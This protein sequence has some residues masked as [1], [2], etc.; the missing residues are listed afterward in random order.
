MTR[1]G[2][3]ESAKDEDAGA[4]AGSSGAGEGSGLDLQFGE[5]G[6]VVVA[7]FG[8]DGAGEAGLEVAFDDAAAGEGELDTATVEGADGGDSD[9]AHG[10]SYAN[11][12]GDLRPRRRGGSG[13]R[14]FGVEESRGDDLAEL[15]VD[16]EGGRA[17]W[18]A[19]AD[20][21]AVRRS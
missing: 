21:R 6:G 4:E 14:G 12:A 10:R 2:R 16:G 18:R 17:G 3:G 9:Q 5:A 11:A 20:W 15:G 7:D 19:G 13:W 1:P 8:E